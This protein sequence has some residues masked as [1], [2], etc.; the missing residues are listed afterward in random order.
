MASI[1][2][3]A[4]SLFFSAFRR[5]L[6]YMVDYITCSIT[7]TLFYGIPENVV[8][9]HIKTEYIANS[10]LLQVLIGDYVACNSPTLV[11][12]FIFL[13][14]MDHEKHIQHRNQR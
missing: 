7:P 3:H 9:K 1:Q 8:K 2:K 10:F 4:G 11:T 6:R 13:T 14:R 5:V 12:L